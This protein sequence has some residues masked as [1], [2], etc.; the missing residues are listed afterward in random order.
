MQTHRWREVGVETRSSIKNKNERNKDI[1][2]P[3]T[4]LDLAGAVEVTERK[5]NVMH[6][7]T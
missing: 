3:D 2:R 6:K 7:R 5:T 4:N 1:Q